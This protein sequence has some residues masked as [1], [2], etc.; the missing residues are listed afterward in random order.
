[1]KKIGILMAMVFLT[2][3]FTNVQAQKV[4][5]LSN[6]L[7]INLVTGFPSASFGASEDVPSSE[8][9]GA[10]FGVKLGNRWY[11]SPQEK[12]GFGLMVN[13]FDFAMALNTG[14]DTYN[15]G[16]GNSGSSDWGRSTMDISFFELGPIGTYAINDDMAIDGYYNLRPT[17]LATA[18]VLTYSNSTTDYTT[19]YGGFGFTN[20]LGTA[21][22]WK[23][24][25]VGIEY[26]M[27]SV[28]AKGTATV[29]DFNGGTKTVDLDD[30]KLKS[31]SVRIL[32]GV[33]F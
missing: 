5:T 29:P 15:D 10:L 23:V 33:K 11:F 19:A 17:V 9:Y 4:R 12:F 1:M 6:G 21:F 24:L 14:T 31:N 8:E 16:F 20:A 2:A 3:L 25:S 26:V 13:W 22:R 30:Q 7:S 18:S 28:T 32:L 27:G